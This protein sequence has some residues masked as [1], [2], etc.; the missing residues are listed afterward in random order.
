MLCH[1]C[2]PFLTDILSNDFG[3]WRHVETGWYTY[4]HGDHA[5]IKA[6]AQAGCE[7]CALFDEVRVKR[8][9]GY[10]ETSEKWLVHQASIEY[11]YE[12]DAQQ[13]RI[14]NTERWPEKRAQ[15]TFH[16]FTV[17]PRMSCLAF[18]IFN[19][20]F[21][22]FS[23]YKE[24]SRQTLPYGVSTSPV[25]TTTM[26]L[27]SHWLDECVHRHLECSPCIRA[28]LPTRV[29]NI[30]ASEEAFDLRL[31]VNKGQ[32]GS[33]VTLSHCW[34]EG[35]KLKLT[36]R[37]MLDFQRD[38]PF[39]EL[40]PT[41]QDAVRLTASLGQ[42][43]LWI[44]ALC[45]LQ[46]DQEDWRREAESMGSVFETAVFS[47][48]ALSAVDSYDGLLKPR[49]TAQVIA[50]VAGSGIGIR[51]RLPS[52]PEALQQSRLETRAWC[53][54]ERV[55]SRRILHV[56]PEQLYWEC[57]TSVICETSPNDAKE[58]D[59]DDVDRLFVGSGAYNTSNYHS[60]DRQA[61]W[62]E[63]VAG[64]SAC[65][66]TKRSDRLPAIAG[67]AE[68]ARREL[69]FG[70]Y[71]H[72]IWLVDILPGLLWRRDFERHGQTTEQPCGEGPSPSWS[73]ASSNGAVEYPL[74]A[75]L[76]KHRPMPSDLAVESRDAASS[77]ILWVTCHI[78][79]GSCK[80]VARPSISNQAAF[81][82]S[83]SLLEHSGLPCFLDTV[84]EPVSKGCYCVI[85]ATF[86]KQ[87]DRM[88]RRR[89]DQQSLSFYLI[90]ERT[91]DHRSSPTT[92][93]ESFGL[94][95]RIG[96]GFAP[97]QKVEG[98]FNNVERRHLE[99]I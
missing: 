62:L 83:G 5:T 45:I 30:A 38:I 26:N 68:K 23:T 65:D 85:V 7:V 52:L 39:D 55:L 17:L 59:E 51:E 69:G 95:R 71:M 25:E 49:N 58:I 73:W 18:E 16:L 94:F 11:R 75:A 42:R 34:G 88:Q 29:L 14:Q 31:Q 37:N 82:A 78:R 41:F 46:D 40:P 66:L 74:L 43:Y 21:P 20:T 8:I 36:K 4:R 33:Y 61:Q 84:D 32:Q 54:Q 1:L 76:H 91:Q 86:D 48:S 72:G 24:Y 28:P 19:P 57:R 9:P 64:Y 22:T 53:L 93:S 10:N 89:Q 15:W 81:R 96:M 6:A 92:I 47:I 70:Q 13:L 60:V 27:V 90:L 99:L 3:N 50:D 63:L 35:S 97:I 98:F 56:A 44:D 2:E 87:R 12:Y 79:R 80:A 77:T 67:L